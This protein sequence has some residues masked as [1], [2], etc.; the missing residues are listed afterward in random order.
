MLLKPTHK[1]RHWR[2]TSPMEQT[3]SAPNDEREL[4]DWRGEEQ[5]SRKREQQM[6]R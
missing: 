3:A 5:H 4:A 6:Q 1:Y 2:G